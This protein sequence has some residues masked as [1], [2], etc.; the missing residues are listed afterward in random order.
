MEFQALVHRVLRSGMLVLCAAWVSSACG[1]GPDDARQS[2]LEGAVGG[3]GAGGPDVAPRPG[4]SGYIEG[5]PYS[6]GVYQCCAK[7]EG[8]ACCGDT[9]GKC[10]AYGGALGECSGENETVEGK[11]ICSHCCAGLTRAAMDAV[12]PETGECAPLG[13]GSLFVCIY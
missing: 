2:P 9:L 5:H 12:S 3:N 1:D 8:R 6:Q 11:D 4:E 10:F 13:P 7:G